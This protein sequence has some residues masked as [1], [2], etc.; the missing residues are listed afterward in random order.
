MKARAHVIFR[1]KVQGVFFRAH[2]E[3]KAREEGL[4][5]WVRNLRDGTV[6]AV[7]EGEKEAIERAIEWCR[8]SQP[9]ARVTATDV[10]WEEF[11]DEF[12]SFERRY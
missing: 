10:R 2:T 8:N 1:G 11:R 12:S 9:Y 6:E 3:G 5:G 7:F 4:R